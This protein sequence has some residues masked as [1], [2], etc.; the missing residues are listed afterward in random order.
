MPKDISHDGLVGL[1]VQITYMIQNILKQIVWLILK[2]L[3]ST[4][5][6]EYLGSEHLKMARTI[7]PTGS[8]VFAIWHEHVMTIMAAH[9]HQEPYMALASRSKDG[10]FAAHIASK[11]GFKAVRGSSRNRRGDKGG[12]E[13]LTEYIEN[14][15]MGVSGGITIDGPKGPRHVCKPGIVIMSHKTGSPILP[16]IAVAS[17]YWEFNSWDRYKLPKPF[18]KIKIIY[19]EPIQIE[20]INDPEVFPQG[21][22][23]VSVAMKSLEPLAAQ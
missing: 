7:H 19:G 4:Y 2:A 9:A 16:V 22:L 8:F 5:K 1:K 6:F 13:A 15:S 17:R 21:A 10:D 18:A 12:K 3:T 23:K 14:L 20:Q 11:F